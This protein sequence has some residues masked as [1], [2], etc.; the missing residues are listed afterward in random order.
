MNEVVPSQETGPP[1]RIVMMPPQTVDQT[2][3]RTASIDLCLAC[4][5]CFMCAC[6]LTDCCCCVCLILIAICICLVVVFIQK[7]NKDGMINCFDQIQKKL[8]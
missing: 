3:K 4:Q 2:H 1:I 6:K 5:R 8:S 7:C